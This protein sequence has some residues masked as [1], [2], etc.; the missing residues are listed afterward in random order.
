MVLR[1]LTDVGKDDL[2]YEIAKNHHARVQEVYE[3]TGT[4]W[5]NYSPEHTK[6]GDPAKPDFIGWSGLP[7]IAVFLEYILGLRPVDPLKGKLLWDIRETDEIGVDKYPLGP[8]ASL[9][10]HCAARASESKE[11]QVNVVSD[12]PVEVEVHWRTG[13]KVVRA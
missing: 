5:E 3:T 9:S 10:L 11:P 6:P 1:G 12:A 13:S 7:P 2:A 8:T 4:F